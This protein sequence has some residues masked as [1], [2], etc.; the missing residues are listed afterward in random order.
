MEGGSPPPSAK[1]KVVFDG[2]PSRY[3]NPSKNSSFYDKEDHVD[4]DGI[5]LT[6][7]RGPTSHLEEER[8]LMPQ[9]TYTA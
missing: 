5:R 1:L 4:V 9:A 7:S 2:L 3:A 6:G 8:G